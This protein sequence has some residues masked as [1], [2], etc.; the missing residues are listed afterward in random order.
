ME[1]RAM[2]IAG[3]IIGVFLVTVIALCV[4]AAWKSFRRDEKAMREAEYRDH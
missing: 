2:V 1:K 4:R 3:C